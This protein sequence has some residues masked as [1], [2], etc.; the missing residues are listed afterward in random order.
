MHYLVR[1]HAMNLKLQD[2][3]AFFAEYQNEPLPERG[4]EDDESLTADQIAQKLNGYKRRE[5]P[6]GAEHLTMF[7]DVQGK[8][9]FYVV[10]AWAG[11]RCDEGSS[12][13][14]RAADSSRHNRPCREP[15]N[16]RT[17]SP[18]SWTP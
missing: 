13:F 5:V 7:I 12:P 11:D 14:S 9:L 2:E 6:I 15:C 4:V 18:S 8:L 17:P 10:A 16:F 1:Q 3:A